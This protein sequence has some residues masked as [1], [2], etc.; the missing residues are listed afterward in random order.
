MRSSA[1]TYYSIIQLCGAGGRD[2]INHFTRISQH[3]KRS[4]CARASTVYQ[5]STW[6]FDLVIMESA[7]EVSDPSDWTDTS[8]ASLSRI[9]ASLRCQV[10]KDYFNTPVITS[11]SHTFCSLCIRRCLAADG[12]CPACRATEQE[13]RLRRN[14]TVQELTDV[15]VAAREAILKVA[16]QESRKDEDVLSKSASQGSK[17]K[18]GNDE[19]QE[20]AQAGPRTRSQRRK[21][22]A[23][24]DGAND[25]VDITEDKEDGNYV[26]EDGLVACPICNKRMKAET[27]FSHL[28]NCE[29]ETTKG[30]QGPSKAPLRLSKSFPSKRETPPQPP[31]E[32]LPQLNYSLLNDK[33]L[34]KK[35][36]ELGIPHFGPKALLVRRHTEWIALWNA[37]CDS[38]RPRSKKELL[39]ELNTWERSQG[40]HAPNGGAGQPSAV[41]RK[42]FDGEGWARKNKGEFDALIANARQKRTQPESNKTDDGKSADDKPTSGPPTESTSQGIPLRPEAPAPIS[43]KPSS[44]DLTRV[45]SPPSP[46]SIFTH[47]DRQP[48]NHARRASLQVGLSGLETRHMRHL[49]LSHETSLTPLSPV[50]GRTPTKPVSENTQAEGIRGGGIVFK[51]TVWQGDSHTRKMPM[52]EVPEDPVDADGAMEVK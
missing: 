45:M 13:N 47:L 43:L 11:C 35:L 44:S 25:I 32:R 42:D 6:S 21:A 33:A 40:G 15:F 18:R 14:V 26:P 39:A 23:N 31:P 4:H 28:D 49:S 8:L 29:E 2:G 50:N 51:D 10:C 22:D 19:D 16:R 48:P 38:P 5:K 24:M 1:T 12:Q 9:D 20:K 34:R 52:F 41:M 17:R 30:R 46:P 27:V 36:E 7:Y 37:N 3:V